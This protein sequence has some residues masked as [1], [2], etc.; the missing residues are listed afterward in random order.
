MLFLIQYHWIWL[1]LAATLGL[2]IGW[3]TCGERRGEGPGGWMMLAAATFALG[4]VVSLLRLL[5]GRFGYWIDIGLLNFAAYFVGCCLG[6]LAAW[7]RPSSIVAG[8]APVAAPIWPASVPSPQAIPDDQSSSSPKLPA[9]PLSESD[10][11]GPGSDGIEAGHPGLKPPGLAGPRQGFA[12]DLKR[13]K[14]IGPQNER[15]LH[16]LGIW[17]YDQIAAWNGQ[18]I[19]WIASFL[20][21]PGRIDRENWVSQAKILASGGTTEFA[22]RVDA[23]KVPTSRGGSGTGD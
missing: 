2:F 6:C 3:S 18:N 12:D 4:L 8:E 11:P 13:I 14:G 21:F 17:H 16:A 7:R 5:P 1:L 10:G 22:K 20:K 19:E 15:R 23:G 9:P